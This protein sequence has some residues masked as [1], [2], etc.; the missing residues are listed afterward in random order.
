MN[1]CNF[2]HL[3]FFD[4]HLGRRIH[5]FICTLHYSVRYMSL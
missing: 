1:Q 3:M 4:S 2:S 5:I